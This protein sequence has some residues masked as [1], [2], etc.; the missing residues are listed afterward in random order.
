MAEAGHHPQAHADEPRR[1]ECAAFNDVGTDDPAATGLTQGIDGQVM[2]KRA[3]R[4]ASNPHTAFTAFTA[5][6]YQL[7]APSGRAWRESYRH[8]CIH[9]RPKRHIQPLCHLKV[10]HNGIKPHHQ[11][12]DGLPFQ[13]LAATGQS[14]CLI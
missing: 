14:E 10:H 9:A 13:S 5:C 7:M 1:C 2:M 8:E 3:P 12:C 6:R 4:W 11:A